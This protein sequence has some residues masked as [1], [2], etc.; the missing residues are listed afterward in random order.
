MYP[1][2]TTR[3][4]LTQPGFFVRSFGFRAE[5]F[6]DDRKQAIDGGAVDF[7][8]KPFNEE[9]LFKAIQAAQNR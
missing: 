2:T 7:L 8:H 5:A 6:E 4:W 1:W 3:R 9:T